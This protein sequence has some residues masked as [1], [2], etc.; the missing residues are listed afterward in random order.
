MRLWILT[1]VSISWMMLSP[2]A[3]APSENTAMMSDEEQAMQLA[4]KHFEKG[5]NAYSASDFTAA[6]REFKAAEALKPS[7]ILD[8]NLALANE[9]QGKKKVA[10]S[11][12]RRYLELLPQAQN[13]SEVEKRIAALEKAVAAEPA[14]P[15]PS[16][17]EGPTPSSPHSFL[18]L[19]SSDPYAA[20]APRPPELPKKKDNGGR[21][22]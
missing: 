14:T 2:C 16:P 13:R 9:K 21:V 8:Y 11:Y 6:I 5:K 4:K 22:S 12:Y 7:A 15:A 1:A 17:S 18:D 3:A 20:A 10:L 19:R